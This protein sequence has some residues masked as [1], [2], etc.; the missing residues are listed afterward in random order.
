MSLF[1]NGRLWITPATMSAV[2]DTAMYN[3][4][5]SVGNV[6]AIVGKS[7][8]GKPDTALHFG[9]AAQARSVLIDGEALRAIEKA[10]DPSSET[11]GPSEVVFIRVNPAVQAALALVDASAA[12]V[13]NLTA[14]DYG[15]R[16]NSVRVKI[17]AGSVSGK[18]LST[19]LG[20]NYNTQDNVGRN[21]FS[22]QYTGA[23]LTAT[24]AVSETQVTLFPG[25][26]TPIII[27]LSAYPTISSLVDRINGVAGFSATVL[28]G[29]HEKP[30][31]KCLDGVVAQDVKTTAYTAKADLQAIIDWFNSASEGYVTAVR[32]AGA[33][34]T[35]INMAWTYLAGGTDGNVTNTEWQTAFDALQTVDV[36]WVVPISPLP[37]IHAMADAHA[38]YMSNIAHMERRCIVGP[39]V[40]TTDLVAIA[41]AKALNSDRTSYTHLGFY[42]YD[43]TGALVL[44]PP[45]ILAGLLG[46]MFAGVNPGTALTNKAI[47]VRG[48]ERILRNPTDTDQLLLGGVLCVEETL[49]GYKVVQ[50]ITTWLIN[51]NYNRRE[52]SVGVAVDFTMRNIRN[53]VDV[54][55]GEK[56]TPAL[57]T[58]AISR[59][60]TALTELSRPEPMGPAVLV[61][62]KVNPPFKNITASI[63]GDVLRIEFQAS[64]VIS[65]NY[66]PI[67]MHAV[68]YSGT[69]TA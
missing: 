3:K 27:E 42:D 33:L 53:A 31:L 43:A 46:G 54:L 22:V 18:K 11:V 63:D 62:D 69:A 34:K 23:E 17:E 55:R 57:L 47:K 24:M 50:S 36:Q 5:L 12:N 59:A 4:N 16:T 32:P 65:C 26:I 64:P 10:F 44:Y 21:A 7:V 29:N 2:D 58:Q 41:A 15:V 30:A 25:A 35:P 20:L 67:V 45:Y 56:M 61:G 39:D 68:P 1:F 37:A 60:E 48:L 28:D 66:I 19:G 49:Q 9:S 8:G 52:V 6:L 38:N 51:T 40:G 13:I 14:Q